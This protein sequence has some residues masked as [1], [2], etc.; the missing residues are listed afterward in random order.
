MSSA[1]VTVIV[2]RREREMMMMACRATADV[3]SMINRGKLSEAMLPW[4]W[5]R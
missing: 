2:E 1:M 4:A 3:T 5:Y